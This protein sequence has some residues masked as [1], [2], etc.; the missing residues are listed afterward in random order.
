MGDFLCLVVAMQVTWRLRECCVGTAAKDDSI[1]LGSYRLDCGA[2]FFAELLARH[3][4]GDGHHH[5]DYQVA[6]AL[7]RRVGIHLQIGKW[8]VFIEHAKTDLPVPGSRP[9]LRHPFSIE[10]RTNPA[11]TVVS[12]SPAKRRP[13]V[14]GF[15]R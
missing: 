2:S 4:T 14:I 9:H 11:I 6:V 3:A 13:I 7:D 15:G 1:L 12:S 5:I 8:P 10:G